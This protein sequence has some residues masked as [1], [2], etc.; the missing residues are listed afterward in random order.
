L[1]DYIRPDS[2]HDCVSSLP[3][4]PFGPLSCLRLHSKDL[5]V[6]NSTKIVILNNCRSAIAY[7]LNHLHL[8]YSEAIRQL[9]RYESEAKTP[10]FSQIKDTV[11]GLGTIRAFSKE[12]Q[13][14]NA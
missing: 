5:Q 1:C 7:I 6:R 4:S 14:L 11:A 3:D 2:G 10:I 13:M 12:K 9:K 8:F